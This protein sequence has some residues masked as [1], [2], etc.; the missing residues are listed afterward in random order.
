VHTLSEDEPA[1]EDCQRKC[2]GE[3]LSGWSTSGAKRLFD[4]ALVL[5]AAPI[6]LPL[7]MVVALSICICDGPPILF[8]QLRIGRGGSPFFIY[9]FRTMKNKHDEQRS[10]TSTSQ[11]EITRLGRLL[12][13]FKLDELPQAFNVLLGDMSL[14]GPRPKIPEQQAGIFS[15]RPGITGSATLAFA[16]EE[17]LFAQVPRE[18]L[19][20]YYR[21]QVLP[22][23]MLLDSDYMAQATL[24]SDVRILLRTV[25]GSWRKTAPFMQV[26]ASEDCTSLDLARKAFY[27]LLRELPEEMERKPG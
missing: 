12:R 7:L 10:I 13:Q 25:S 24:L 27:P 16:C 22:V 20:E 19:P 2:F 17:L 14:V 9:K 15:C 5:A 1:G 3:I 18:Q 11:E 23:K 21:T 26:E 6:L 4:I 8:W